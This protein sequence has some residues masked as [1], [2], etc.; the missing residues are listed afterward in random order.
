MSY[1]EIDEAHH[2]S[3]VV[4]SVGI[5]MRDGHELRVF[6]VRHP[7]RILWALRKRGVHVSFD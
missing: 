3:G 4:P 5:R 2:L 6:A 1:A 7:E